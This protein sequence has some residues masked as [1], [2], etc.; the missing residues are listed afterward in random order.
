VISEVKTV[1]HA[2]SGSDDDRLD[3]EVF[4]MATKGSM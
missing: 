3:D 2:A 4:S 1:V